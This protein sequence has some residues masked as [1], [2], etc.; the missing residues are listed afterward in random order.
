MN[1]SWSEIADADRDAIIGYIWLYS[2]R[3]AAQMDALFDLAATKLADFPYSGKVGK[4]EGTR[5]LLPHR[6]YRLIYSVEVD[7]VVILRIF[8][9]SRQWPPADDNETS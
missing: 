6:S 7:K 5:E 3:A 9:T 4:L 2:P 1:V 8:H